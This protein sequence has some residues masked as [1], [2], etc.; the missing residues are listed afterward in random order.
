MSSPVCE[1][2]ERRPSGDKGDGVFAIRRFS[3]GELVIRGVIAARPAHNDS[4]AVEVNTGEFVHEGGLSP[5]VNHSCDPSCGVRR[6]SQ[7]G[8]NLIARRPILR[9]EEI[10]IDYAMH[11]YIIEHF[12]ER[13]LCGTKLCRG[14]VTGWRD[15]P[16]AR[17]A[18]YAGLVVSYLFERDEVSRTSQ[19]A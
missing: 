9:D 5:I 3:A 19:A 1:G 14:R 18:V 12:P 6:N 4:H 15:L 7:G 8:L 2:Y 11:S 17:R 10:T 16:E 13:C